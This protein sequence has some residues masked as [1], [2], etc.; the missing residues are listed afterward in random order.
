MDGLLKGLKNPIENFREIFPAARV[1]YAGVEYM[2]R[3]LKEVDLTPVAPRTQ[4]YFLDLWHH[5]KAEAGL[6]SS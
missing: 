4:R 2:L 5:P 6:H 1:R 3:T